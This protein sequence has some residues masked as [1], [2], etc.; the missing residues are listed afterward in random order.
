MNIHLPAI[1]MFTRGTR[2]WPIPTCK[3]PEMMIPI[4]NLRYGPRKHPE[5]D[6]HNFFCPGRMAFSVPPSQCLLHIHK[7]HK[8]HKTRK[9]IIRYI[10]YYILFIL[11]CI[12]LYY[13]ILYCIILYYIFLFI[14]YY[15]ILFYLYYII[16][17]YFI[18]YYIIF[19][20]IFKSYKSKASSDHSKQY[21]L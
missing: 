7:I 12:V 18:L 16:L 19:P 6:P 15:I 4:C 8:I 5:R 2:F 20:Q 1:L 9:I 11:Y 21:H 13:I 3:K 17:Y 14:L 10:L